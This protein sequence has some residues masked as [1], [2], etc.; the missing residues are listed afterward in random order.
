MRTSD[1]VGRSAPSMSF[2]VE[3]GK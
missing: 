3:T 1:M 2:G